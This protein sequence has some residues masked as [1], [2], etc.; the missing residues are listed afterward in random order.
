MKKLMKLALC[1]LMIFSVCACSSNKEE[2]KKHKKKISATAVEKDLT[3]YKVNIN[4]YD[5]EE[6]TARLEI[7]QEDNY[8]AIGYY[9]ANYIDN[10]IEYVLYHKTEHPNDFCTVYDEKMRDENLSFK[11]YQAKYGNKLKEEDVIKE[12]K[13]FL[14]KYDLTYD[15]LYKWL[16]STAHENNEE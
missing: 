5:Y 4:Y 3:P 15:E 16:V 1:F 2:P 9:P 13:S 11:E 10:K 6:N 12:F 14:K 8:F 7:E